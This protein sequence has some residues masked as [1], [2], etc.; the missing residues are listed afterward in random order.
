M[1][2]KLLGT[3]LAPAIRQVDPE[4]LGVDPSEFGVS[5]DIRAMADV[6]LDALRCHKTQLR[7]GDPRSV[8]PA[9][10][11]PLLLGVEYFQFGAGETPPV[12]ATDVFAGL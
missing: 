10:I 3:D 4:K 8:F 9:G 5:V 6:K 12:G 2:E 7:D 11:V 1:W